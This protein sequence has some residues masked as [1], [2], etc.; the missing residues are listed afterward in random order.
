MNKKM[1]TVLFIL[2]G[3]IVNVLLALFFIVL[4]MIGVTRLEPIIGQAIA[5]WIPFVFLGGILIAMIIYQKL[6][7]WV[8][9]RFNLG[10]KM[11]PLFTFR[12][13]K[14]LD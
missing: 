1:N 10:D 5:N 12:K 6:S 7:K 9:N 14:K 13:S 3:T 11:E 8:M 2:G 4:L